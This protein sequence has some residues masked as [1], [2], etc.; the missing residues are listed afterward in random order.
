MATS[1]TLVGIAGAV[2]L[3]GIMVSVFVYEYNNAPDDTVDPDNPDSKMAIFKAAY[4]TLN[5][6]EDIDGDSIPNYDDSDIDGNDVPDA[7]Q[8]G[9]LVVTVPVI[10]GALG[11]PTPPATTTSASHPLELLTGVQTATLTLTYTTSAPTLPVGGPAPS[12]TIRVKDA[13]GEQVAASTSADQQISGNSVTV[14]LVISEVELPAGKYTIEIVASAGPN[15]SYKV[16]PTLDY[17]P[18]HRAP[19]DTNPR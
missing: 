19:V 11:P 13:A 18:A 1:D 9:N 2:L 12:M 15:T 17:G 3:V 6:T 7:N 16:A 14:T 5:A 4:P 10:Q 8:P